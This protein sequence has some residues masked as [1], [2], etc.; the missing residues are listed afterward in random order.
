[1]LLICWW[2]LLLDLLFLQLNL[3]FLD[4][5]LLELLVLNTLLFLLLWSRFRI[6]T[7][8]RNYLPVDHIVSAVI[9]C[10]EVDDLASAVHRDHLFVV[11]VSGLYRRLVQLLVRLLI[12]LRV[13]LVHI[14]VLLDDLIL[15]WAVRVVMLLLL[16]VVTV[17][18]NL[19]RLLWNADGVSHLVCELT[20][21]LDF[22]FDR[23]GHIVVFVLDG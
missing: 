23:L 15:S 9:Y 20:Y 18:L 8:T 12:L 11:T 4:L 10:I 16:T 5:L 14:L 3:L 1:M 17:L 19:D 13:A 21:L 2:L 22:F 6:A 7:L